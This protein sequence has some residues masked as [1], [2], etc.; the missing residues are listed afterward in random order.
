MFQHLF[1]KDEEMKNVED[2]MEIEND[3]M[4]I[5]HEDVISE[6]VILYDSMTND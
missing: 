5:I 2:E 4:D 1:K 6:D 3:N